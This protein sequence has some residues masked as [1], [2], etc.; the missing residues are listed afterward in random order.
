V[1]G[2]QAIATTSANGRN[3]MLAPLAVTLSTRPDLQL[4]LLFDGVFSFLHVSSRDFFSGK[5][6]VPAARV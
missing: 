4:M 2:Q 5:S 6:R 3:T 1:T